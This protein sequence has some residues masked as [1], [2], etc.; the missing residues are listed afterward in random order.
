VSSAQPSDGP[1][2]ARAWARFCDVHRRAILLATLLV[3]IL[4]LWG[5]AL[6]YSDLRPDMRELL[7]ASDVS[8][9]DLDL[10]SQRVGGFAQL[11]VILHGEDVAAMKR[12]AGDLAA[13]LAEE[14]PEVVRWVEYRVDDVQ[15][16]FQ[17]RALLFP[18][19]AQLEE[20]RD[21]LAARIEWEKER[22]NPLFIPLD[23]DA[24]RP[25]V[26]GLV[27]RLLGSQEQ[28]LSRFP[29]GWFEGPMDLGGG[30]TTH[31]VVVLV[32]LGSKPDDYGTVVR[33]DRTV[34]RHVADLDPRKYAPDLE[35]AY[36]GYVS[37][38][39]LEH[40][41]LAEDLVWA[42]VL[43]VLA[44]ALAM[45]IYYRTWKSIPAVG[46]PLFA[47]T[48]ATFGL[49]EL[50]VGHLN[51]NTAFLGSIVVGNGINVGLI[52]FARYIEER[53]RGLAPL[54]AMETAVDTTWLATLTAALSAGVAYASLMSTEFRGFNQFGLIGGLGMTLSWLSAYV[55]TPPLALTWE[56]R[57]SLVK[58]RERPAR[59]LF[60]LAVSHVVERWPRATVA[61]AAAVTLASL[62]GVARFAREPI[63]YDFSRL[64]DLRALREGGPA[65]W[66]QRVTSIFGSQ[67]TP[68]VLLAGDEAEAREVA[69]RLEAKRRQ[70]GAAS[71]IGSVVSV[72]SFVPE[73]QEEKLPVVRQIRE[74]LGPTT[75]GMLPAEQRERV[76]RILPPPDLRPFTVEDLPRTVKRQLTEVDG[77]IGTP[78]LVYPA[79]T[80][81]P[82]DG[83][84]V[85]RS[86]EE[87]RSVALPRGDIPMAST[88]L[89]FADVLLAIGRDGPRATILSLSGVVL[90]VVV[91]FALGKRQARSLKDAA[92]VLASLA[93]GVVWFGGMAALLDLKLNM[94]NFI[95]LPITF[96]IGVDYATNIFQ[97]RRLD[98]SE[99][100]AEILRTTGGAVALCSV[101]TIVGYSSLLVARNQ[102]LIS[103]GLLADVGEVACLAAS[104]F[105]LPALLRLRELRRLRRAEAA[106]PAV[107][108]A[109]RSG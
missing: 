83:R 36:G 12:F 102:A 21:T 58:P 72:A 7:P 24:P 62:G 63:E 86:A 96:G 8:S 67:L 32:R 5:T 55:V 101:T 78:V 29:T 50:F 16:F 90:L 20:L 85:L 19:K 42:T 1:T 81:N 69:R 84:H 2:R 91:A 27:K 11:S 107:E 74:L 56:R 17:Q 97:R 3:S 106:S 54:P 22:A 23:E 109:A 35:V 45:T 77:R 18:S 57:G 6:L 49:A 99:R 80:V 93:V 75:L 13:R 31:A 33:L 94:L 79:A 44:V 92:W 70:N 26:E 82:W 66:D 47:G 108:R 28:S 98:Q 34:R 30:R 87:L 89:V 71:T 65:W 51:S 39:I 52:L 88:Q 59:P 37:N 38:T 40:N 68:T 100:I 105:A 48:F 4:G 103:F 53:R 76:A 15:R 10:V 64:R 43:V 41:A 73:A 104:L 60:T 25:D 95:A 46:I 14:P 9:R 61:V